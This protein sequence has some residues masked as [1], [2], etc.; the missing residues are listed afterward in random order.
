MFTQ[1]G[2]H[3]WY[4]VRYQHNSHPPLIFVHGAG[5]D[6]TIWGRVARELRPFT[7]YAVD[8]PGHG[9]SSGPAYAT[10]ESTANALYTWLKAVLEEPFILAGHSMGGAIAQTLALT[11]PESL[12]GLILIG[13][14]A[15]LRVHPHLLALLNQ[16]KKAE[17]AR[18]LLQWALAPHADPTLKQRVLRSMMQCSLKTIQADF[19]ACNNFDV[20]A[21]I[22][23]IRVPTLIVGM[24]Q[25]RLTPPKY[26]RY[27]TEHIPASEETLIPE[28]GHMVMLEQPGALA[29]VIRNWMNHLYAPGNTPQ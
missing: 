23:H 4:W 7:V 15:R 17:A 25:D 8:L 12:A 2:P 13:T 19:M 14:G 5:A 9:K 29:R 28:S 16:K 1:T 21:K 11:H 24:E 3:R 18:W 26:A 22:K 10:I 27:L 20:M 6:H